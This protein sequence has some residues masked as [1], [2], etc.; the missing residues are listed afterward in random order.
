M[1]ASLSIDKLSALPVF[2]PHKAGVQAQYHLPHV[3]VELSYLSDLE[4][5]FL[6]AD[7]EAS[8]LEYWSSFA[9]CTVHSDELSMALVQ[10]GIW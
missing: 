7:L 10:R 9:S 3:A 4:E 8:S 6:L 5:P 2:I 1:Q